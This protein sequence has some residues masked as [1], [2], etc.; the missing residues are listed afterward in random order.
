M[1]RRLL[2]LLFFMTQVSFCSSF[3]FSLEITVT[4]DQ[5]NTFSI[6]LPDFKDKFFI[7]II[8]KILDEEIF[9]IVEREPLGILWILEQLE[10]GEIDGRFGHKPGYARTD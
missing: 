9:N 3:E 1:L 6:T 10:T 4:N 2:L 8:D 5:Q 7:I